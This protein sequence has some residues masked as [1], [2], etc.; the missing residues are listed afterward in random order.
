VQSTILKKD[1]EK[2][3]VATSAIIL[4]V[5]NEPGLRPLRAQC[6]AGDRVCYGN[7]NLLFFGI[8]MDG[9]QGPMYVGIFH[10]TAHDE[11]PNGEDQEACA[12]SQKKDVQ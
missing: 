11:A 12:K 3:L 5:L 8:A 7:H 6:E 4:F 2:V 1:D 10:H 9:L